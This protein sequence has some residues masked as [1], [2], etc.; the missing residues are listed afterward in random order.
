MVFAHAWRTT[1]AKLGTQEGRREALVSAPVVITTST[2]A[3]A[4]FGVAFAAVMVGRFESQVAVELFQLLLLQTILVTFVSGAGYARAVSTS[5]AESGAARLLRGYALFALATAAFI[6]IMEAMVL[7]RE[8]VERFATPDR[9]KIYALVAGGLAA[10]LQ[11]ILQG[12]IL[13]ATGPARVFLPMVAVSAAFTLALS[14]FLFLD[15]TGGALLLTYVGYQLALLTVFMLANRAAVAALLRSAARGRAQP[16]R[17]SAEALGFGAINTAVLLVFFLFRELWSER[18]DADIAAASFFAVRIS[19]TYLGILF[20]I[21]AGST[22]LA[23]F[24]GD[25]AVGP[26]MLARLAICL[27]VGLVALSLLIY[28]AAGLQTVVPLLA[29]CLAMQFAADGMRIPGSLATLVELQH[30]TVLSFA[31]I[32]LPAT[33]VAA[34]I[35]LELTPLA[36]LFSFYAFQLLMSAGQIGAAI[37]RRSRL[38]RNRS[39]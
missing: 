4:A 37:G 38:E 6:G 27:G 20:Y 31:L 10:G 15:L 1:L 11:A 36:A 25:S 34:L 33:I 32:S 28:C 7:P 19:E 23:R 8:V 18:V 5:Y 24:R 9:W 17:D 29:L 2:A 16:L 26:R 3:R 21:S 13:R 30:G 35:A 22:L 39:T 14:G 12:A